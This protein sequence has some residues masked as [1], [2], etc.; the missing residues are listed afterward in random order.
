M[1]SI[2][3]IIQSLIQ[4]GTMGR[5]V[6]EKN[7]YNAVSE[8]ISQAGYKNTDE[9]V[10]NPDM[11]PPPQPPQPTVDEKIQAQK[12][13]VELQK[14]QTDAQLSIAELKLKQESAAVEL[15]IKQQE[16]EIKK[17]ELELSKAELALEAVQ[18]RPVKIGK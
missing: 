1:S 6:T 11:M 12:S 4:N 5:L 10:S 15:A 8:F 2:M 18:E 17:S 7:I 9:F 13:Q 16:L 3:Q 14:L